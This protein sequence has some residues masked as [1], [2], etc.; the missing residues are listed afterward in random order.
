MTDPRAKDPNLE[1]VLTA[2]AVRVFSERD[3]AKRLLALQELWARD[4]VLYEDEHVVTGIEAISASVGALLDNLPPG[5]RFAPDGP[6]VGHHGLARLKWIA[7]DAAGTPGPASGIDVAFVEHGRI[8]SLYV[9][10]NPFG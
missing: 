5:T 2:N 1:A 9:F 10:L 6:V 4:G 3:A 7:V 8:T